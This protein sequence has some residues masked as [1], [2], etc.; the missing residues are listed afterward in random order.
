MKKGKESKILFVLSFLL[1]AGCADDDCCFFDGTFIVPSD[2][3][4]IQE[5]VDFALPGETVLVQAGVYSPTTNGEFFPIFMKDGVNIEGEDPENTILDSQGGNY[6]LDLFNYDRGVILNLTLRG[7]NSFLGGAIYAESSSGILSNLYLIGNRAEEAG[8]AIY[9]VNSDGL[10]MNNLVVSGNASSISG[11]QIPAQVEADDSDL[12]FV[13]N[14]VADG[15]SDGVR[16]N[17]GS[18]GVYENNIFYNNG[19]ADFGVGLADTDEV[20]AA[21]IQYNICFNNAEADFFLNGADQSA[22]QAND[23]P[24]DGLI[25]ANFN[26]APLFSDPFANLFTLQPGSPA[27]NAGNPDPAFNNPDG[28]RNDIGAFGGPFAEPP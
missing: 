5:A 18:A 16:I 3:L 13:N 25:F 12:I 23:L 7:G 20:T 28:S 22:E 4:T 19:F 17:F 8:S 9:A 1:L 10:T 21:R 6:L 27:L 14:V 15:D 11:S 26:A 24:T 2:F